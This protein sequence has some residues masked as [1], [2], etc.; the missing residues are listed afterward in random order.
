MEKEIDKNL[1]ELINFFKNLNDDEIVNTEKCSFILDLLNKIGILYN[2]NFIS[3]WN[4]NFITKNELNQYIKKLETENKNDAAEKIK[5]NMLDEAAL[6]WR[7]DD[8]YTFSVADNNDMFVVI[9]QLFKSSNNNEL[10]YAS[11][12]MNNDYKKKIEK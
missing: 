7:D 9:T 5:H 8:P 3:K 4:Y 1:Y 6:Y 11:E 10:M 2:E 12:I